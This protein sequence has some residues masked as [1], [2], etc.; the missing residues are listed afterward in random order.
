VK[1]RVI[2]P[3]S[4]LATREPCVL[5]SVHGCLTLAKR[6]VS[7]HQ[8]LHDMGKSI[9]DR[10]RKNF[11]QKLIDEVNT[12]EIRATSEDAPNTKPPNSVKNYPVR[13]GGEDEGTYLPQE[14]NKSQS[15]K[16]QPLKANGKKKKGKSGKRRMQEKKK[17]RVR[18]AWLRFREPGSGAE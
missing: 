4:C 18:S 1:R 3:V 9:Q 2:T 12:A 6:A 8:F 10:Q 17:R 5:N 14:T 11:L 16:E 7:E 15:Y 13:F